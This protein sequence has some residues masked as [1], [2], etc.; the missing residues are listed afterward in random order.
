MINSHCEVA[1]IGAGPYGLSVAAHLRA[2]GVNL[3]IFGKA[4][5]TWRSHMPDAMMLK[6]EGFAS[7]L[8]GPDRFSTLKDYCACHN[9]A[10][11]DRGFPIPRTD[12]VAYA[13]WFR[14]R[15]VPNLEEVN[16]VALT[17]QAA[18]F[19]LVLE[20]GETVSAKR[21]VMAV[22]VSF[23]QYIPEVLASL[24]KSMLSHSYDH[25]TVDQFR[26]REVVVLGAGASAINLAYELEAAGC[27]SRMLVRGSKVEYN[28]FPSED[29]QSLSYRVSNPPSPIGQ[30]WRSYFCAKLPQLFYH[31]PRR[32]R[33]RA[34]NSHI[35]AAGG[36]YMREKVEGRVT[37]L[38]KHRLIKAEPVANRVRL[39][40][41][42]PRG[43]RSTLECDHLIAATGYR[44]DVR[45]IAFLD[46]AI[47]RQISSNSEVVKLSS[48]FETALPGLYAIGMTAMADFGPLLRFMVGTDF[49]APRLA[50]HLRRQI[51][52]ER[53]KDWFLGLTAT[54]RRVMKPSVSEV[55]YRTLR[56]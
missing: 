56:H 38:L 16:V 52:G 9:I 8:S 28:S 45:R 42:G 37:Q 17:K 29:T 48:R 27:A 24:P 33:A 1:I 22:G 34:V 53:T 23:F 7:N 44:V 21:V 41:A 2:A 31:L 14:L 49:V 18:N 25:R 51:Q 5:D 15:H 50:N 12:F 13:D 55:G 11:A 10:Y 6:S 54:I 39:T 4:M 20:H 19:T 36:W 35:H 46:D 47:R 30:G 32:L 43:T 3:R 40:L 26:D